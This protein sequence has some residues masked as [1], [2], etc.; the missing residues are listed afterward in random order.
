MT[1]IVALIPA[2]AG[3]K[4]VPGKNIRLLHGHPLL[5]YSIVAAIRAKTIQRVIV[6]TDSEE[7]ATLAR[8]Y[9]AETPYLRPA[10]LAGDKAGDLEVVTHAL[11]WMKQ[12]E[13]NIPDFIVHL[14]PTTPL[15]DPTVVDKAVNLVLGTSPSEIT[16]LRSAHEMAE[17]AYKTVEIAENGYFKTLGGSADL[18]TANQP[19]QMFP[20]TYQPNGY[21]DVLKSEYVLRQHKVHGDKVVPFITEHAVE[22]DSIQEFEYLEYR[23]SRDLRVYNLLFS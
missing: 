7:Y 12:H 1:N 16:A 8:S 6:S 9:G 14:R 20:K 4:G 10:E 3:S 19:R 15:R 13:G 2:R 17:T 21:V 11:T 5:A 18:E 23:I 22:V